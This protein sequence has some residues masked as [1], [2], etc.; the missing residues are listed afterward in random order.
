M[1]HVELLQTAKQALASCFRDTAVIYAQT[2]T[3][4]PAGL[5]ATLGLPDGSSRK[6]VVEAKTSGQPRSV[7]EACFQL[8]GYLAEHPGSH[9][10][11]LAPYITP[12]SAEICRHAGFGYV[13]LAGNCRLSVGP[14]YIERQG[15]PNPFIRKAQ[16]Y[17]LYKPVAS[18]VLRVLLAH[19]P[20]PWK[21][22]ELAKEASV[23]LGH[24]YNVKRALLD[25]EWTAS[26]TKSVSLTNPAAVLA[27][28]ASRYNFRD[29]E[30]LEYYCA[31]D[32][33]AIERALAEI[34]IAGEPKVAL[35]GFSAASRLAPVVKH[36]RVTAYVSENPQEV[37]RKL[38]FKKVSSGANVMLLEPYD[39]GVFYGAKPTG[40]LPIVSPVQAYLDLKGY[41]GRGEEAA[42]ELLEKVLRP[43]WQKQ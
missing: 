11:V 39:V 12:A 16:L 15:R 5:W 4:D 8:Q 14:V 7:R 3:H 36:Q 20:R 42:D 41:R 38:N 28:W 40:G 23:S 34:A 32:V 31:E 26:E 24:A 9:G 35:T 37:A 25:R 30:V 10:V 21:L 29:N 33:P 13:D 22:N 43:L 17:N 27:E 6:L 1:K 18:R 2:E 19:P